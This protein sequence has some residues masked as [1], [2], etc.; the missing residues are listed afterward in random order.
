MVSN[1]SIENK[2]FQD[3]VEYEIQLQVIIEDDSYEVSVN[4]GL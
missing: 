2:Q 1:I 3:H 4:T